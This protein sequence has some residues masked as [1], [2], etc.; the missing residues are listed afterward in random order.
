M[1]MASG[2]VRVVAAVAGLG[3]VF[4]RCLGALENDPY[5]VLLQQEA[6]SGSL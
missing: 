1:V 4:G 3:L 5:T 6:L 2:D